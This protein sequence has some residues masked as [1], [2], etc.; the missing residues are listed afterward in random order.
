ML[1][2]SSRSSEC[3]CCSCR[4]VAITIVAIN[5]ASL[6]RLPLPEYATSINIVNSIAITDIPD[7][8]I[9]NFVTDICVNICIAHFNDFERA[10]HKEHIISA[11]GE[12]TPASSPA[13]ASGISSG[14]AAGIGIGVA[15]VVVAVGIIAFCLLR[16]KKK[17]TGPRHSM[18]I[19]KPLPGSGRTYPVRDEG[20]RKHDSY[21]K[22]GNDIEMTSNRYED[23]V[24]SQQPRTMV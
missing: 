15:I 20:E 14:A 18:D 11:A 2:T 19:S 6:N 17:Q 3:T 5:L 10:D 24:P 13:P 22:Y 1:T 4:C 16:N 8:D 7:V 9:A 23:M 21:G 12:T